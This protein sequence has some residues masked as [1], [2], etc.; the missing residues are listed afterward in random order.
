MIVRPPAGG[1]ITPLNPDGNAFSSA[2]G[3]GFTTNDIAESEIPF[4]VIPVAIVELTGDIA[5]GPVAGFSDIVTYLD[6]S[7]AYIYKDATNIYFRIR[8][9][10]I[11]SGSKGYS[12]LIDTDGKIGNSG[13][14]ADPNFIAPGNNTPG[15]PGFEYEVVLQTNTQVAVYNIDGVS[16][17]PSPVSF[18]LNTNSQIS[19][20]LSTD[21]NNPDYFYDW[22]VPFTAI[23][24]PSSVRV[25]VTTITSPNSA[26]QSTRSDIYG[27]NDQ[28]HSSVAAAWQKVVEAQPSISLTPFTSVGADCTNPPVVNSPISSGASVAVTGTWTRLDASKPGSANITLFKNNIAAGSAVVTSGG[29]W[30]INT[31]V[32]PGDVF[33]AKAQ[34]SGESQCLSSPSVKAACASIPTAPSITCASS[35]GITGTV[36]LGATVHIYLVSAANA[37][38]TAT[39]LTTGLV[40]ANNA[41]NRTFNY[42]STN[43]QSGNACQGQNN[44]LAT[45]TYMFITDN[46]GCL[47]APAFI[48]ITGSSSSSWAALASNSLNLTTPVYPYQT[49]ISGTG[50]AAGQ[51]LRLFIND[52]YFST[53][54][55]TGT[56]FSF[57]GLSL[58]AGNKLQIFAQAS[59][60]CT[61]VSSPFTVSCYTE[62]PVITTGTGGN[63]LTGVTAVNGVSAYPGASVQLYKG[64]SPSGTATGA[65]VTVN[66]NGGW[67]VT[68]PALTANDTYYARQTANGCTSPSS[69]SVTVLSPAICPLITG[70]YTDAST[71]VNGTLPAA[72]TGTIRLYLDGNLIGSQSV[73]SATSWNISVPANTLYYNGSLSAT[74]QAAGTA[75]STGCTSTII[76][77]ASP[78]TPTISPSS[79]TILAGQSVTYNVSNVASN[80]WY[81]LSDNNGTTY[82]TSQ[83]RTT[84]GNFSLQSSAFNTP[85]TYPLKISADALTGCPASFTL[86]NV[87]VNAITVPVRFIS[88]GG[89]KRN[90]DILIRWEVADEWNVKEYIIERSYNGKDFVPAG[91][92]AFND[93]PG[94]VNKYSFTDT[95]ADRSRSLFYRIKQVD[96]DL[97]PH[98]SSIIHL[99]GSSEN[100]MQIY[101]N[102]VA[103][104]LI[105]SLNAAETGSIQM[106]LY[107]VNGN[108]LLSEKRTI[109]RGANSFSIPVNNVMPGQYIMSI[110]AGKVIISSKIVKQ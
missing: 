97:A 75:Q 52:E 40:Y 92:A 12:F 58:S 27:V 48:C 102:P 35:K 56:S 31:T 57:S 68:V 96:L 69:A 4:K 86:A 38:P 37:S 81:A 105:V 107:T 34:S 45:G 76:G 80:T 26:L 108:L 36:P 1:T 10:N 91:K 5:T 49:V 54:T 99:S 42:Y 24:S 47:S 55:A 109:Y 67:S 82:G 17:P 73:T 78:A 22:F 41:S 101:P 23:G 13:P 61:T 44:L 95:D 110:R 98:Y 6:G 29:S 77:C 20:A 89:E 71:V 65:A 63:L 32:N 33:F 74:A 94:S 15:N 106:L 3:T 16:S 8:I 30:S 104:T 90:N 79:T 21:N 11:V 51:V 2:S 83:Y 103:S 14:G 25:A 39:Q 66:T 72:F 53:I 87:T 64:I 100:N 59:G 28:L 19:V 85:G 18:P 7:G 62:P 60:S 50:S 84:T 88:V 93:N 70:G 46:G 43:P 9:G